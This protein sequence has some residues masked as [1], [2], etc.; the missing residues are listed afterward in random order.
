MFVQKPH[1]RVIEQQ[2]GEEENA[3]EA[4]WF[5]G[6]HSYGLHGC[7]RCMQRLQP[8]LETLHA[9]SLL[10]SHLFLHPNGHSHL[11]KRSSPS[12]TYLLQ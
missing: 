2:R 7:R 9:T 11:A 6:M 12:G 10:N 5:V 3:E 4:V 1:N 8:W